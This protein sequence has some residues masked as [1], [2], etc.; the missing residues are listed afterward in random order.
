MTVRSR[1]AGSPRWAAVKTS[2]AGAV[3]LW[4]RPGTVSVAVAP[5]TTEMAGISPTVGGSAAVTVIV[6][7]AVFEPPQS[8]RAA[9]ERFTVVVATTAGALY[10][11]VPDVASAMVP[12]AGVAHLRVG[13]GVPEALPSR[14]TVPPELTV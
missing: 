5:E 6:V 12:V 2:G 7:V 13:R 9:S 4:S 1:N 3:P 14:A 8:L 11:V 10:V